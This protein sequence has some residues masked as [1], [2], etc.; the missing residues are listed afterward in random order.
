MKRVTTIRFSPR[1]DM[2]MWL[3][4]STE[5]RCC[6]ICAFGVRR[7]ER[8]PRGLLVLGDLSPATV[9]SFT[10]ANVYVMFMICK[11]FLV[12]M[13]LSSSRLSALPLDAPFIG[14]SITLR[15]DHLKVR[16]PRT[17]PSVMRQSD[18]V[19]SNHQIHQPQT[20]ALVD[21]IPLGQPVHQPF[22]PWTT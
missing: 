2:T 10:M 13:R 17:N 15:T 20:D 5:L 14:T 22:L 4:P 18:E 16:Y 3:L 7:V 21:D 6:R 1:H 11:G 9:I 8:S 19:P 12:D